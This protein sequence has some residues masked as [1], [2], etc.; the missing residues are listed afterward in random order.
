MSDDPKPPDD[1]TPPSRRGPHEPGRRPTVADVARAAGVSSMTVSNVV[2]GRFGSMTEQTRAAVE[3]AIREIGYRPH[4]SGRSL[5]LARRFSIGM[6]VIDESPT[7]LADPF[8][9]Y[10]I[11][12][13]SNFLNQRDYGL[14]VQG[15]SAEQLQEAALMKRHETDALCVFISGLPALRRELIARFATLG[16]P[17]VVFQEAVPDTPLLHCV[18]QDD[19]G[20]AKLLAE[21]VLGRGAER[22]LFLAPQ[23]RWPAIER[24]V[25]GAR[26]AMTEAGKADGFKVVPC[27]DES[28]TATQRALADEVAASGWPSAV[29]GGNDQIGIAAMKW[30]IAQGLR[31]PQDILVSGF[32]AF[33]AWQYSDPVLTTVSS[34]AYAM[35]AKAGE[36]V[37]DALH[38]H[39]P[40]QHEYLFPVTIQ[41][42]AST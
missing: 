4:A 31:V 38:G 19:F 17:V 11:A 27:G 35:G 30:I 29:M 18:R 22:I 41:I 6:V 20:G 28:F 33:D 14:V 7:F 42:E 25:A 10:L 1:T 13:L 34:P 26:A 15:M 36:I 23:I 2:N 9:T 21:H 24:R 8:I 16:Q 32:N 5:K 40:A 39:P 37:L 3:R 12:G